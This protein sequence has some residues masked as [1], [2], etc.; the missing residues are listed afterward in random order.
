MPVIAYE[1]NHNRK[2]IFSAMKV[3]K[4]PERVEIGYS[5]FYKITLEKCIELEK[6]FDTQDLY[7][8]SILGNRPHF[9]E[10]FIYEWD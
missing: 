6:V 7:L 1:A 5:V 3:R 4:L 8:F 10:T 2:F 9:L